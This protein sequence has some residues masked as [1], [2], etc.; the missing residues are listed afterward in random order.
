VLSQC[1]AEVTTARNANE[2]IQMLRQQRPDVIVSDIGM[3]S[4]D[5]FQFIREVRGLSAAEGGHTPAIALTAYARSEDRTRA[6]MA[7]FQVHL[8]KPI[9]PK[10]LIATVGSVVGRTVPNV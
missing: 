9:E 7:G 8:A 4:K 3:P 10:E 2:A 5:G 1:N 6:M